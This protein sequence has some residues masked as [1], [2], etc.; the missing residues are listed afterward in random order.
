MNVNKMSYINPKTD[1][2]FKKIFGSEES[3]EILISFLDSI[4]YDSENIIEDLEIIDPYQAPEIKGRKYTYLDVKAKLTDG[5][6]VII[7]MQMLNA[8]SFEKRILYNAAKAY[9]MQLTTGQDYPILNPVFAV[10]ITDFIMFEEFPSYRSCF[11][12]KET[13]HLLDYLSNDFRLIFVE[14]PKFKKSLSELETLLEKWV[15][16]LKS[17]SK[18]DEVPENLKGV[19]PLERA[20]QIAER[21]NLTELELE[22]ITREELFIQDQRGAITL[23]HQEGISEGIEIGKV[24]LIIALLTQKIGT[25]PP[26]VA[27]QI[28]EL[29]REKINQF[30]RDFMTINNLQEL[31]SWLT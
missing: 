30:T 19:Y 10:T 18:L 3:K 31:Q 4:I 14:L 7:E 9:S 21:T 1:F 25:I 20:F 15:Y 22:E 27:K 5:T 12:L 17:A 23:A 24:E 2:A 13:T 6:K 11:V 26:E 16:F 29:S 8:E 28:K